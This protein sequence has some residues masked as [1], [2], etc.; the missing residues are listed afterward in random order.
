MDLAFCSCKLV[1]QILR[2]ALE[3]Y[4][5][6]LMLLIM[7]AKK[8]NPINHFL[9]RETPYIYKRIIEF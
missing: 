1:F 6:L 8:K 2:I 9:V 4:Y 7:G 3:F 5:P